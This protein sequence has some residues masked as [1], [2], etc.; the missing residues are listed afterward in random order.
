MK[1]S[2]QANISKPSGRKRLAAR[3]VRPSKPSSTLD[4][5][6]DVQSRFARAVMS[7]LTSDWDMNPFA[8][9]G[10]ATADAVAKFVKPNDRLTSFERIEI[11]NRQYWFRLIDIMYEDYPGLLAV[12]GQKRFNH[13]CQRYLVAYPSRSGL[14][15][16]LGKSLEQFITEQP[17]VTA[18]YTAVAL[19]VARFEW[20]QV[21]AFDAAR[22]TPL[23]V[24]D[25]LGN[26]PESARLGLQPYI[27]ILE[28]DYAVDKLL[29][30]VK[31]QAFRSEASNAT[32]GI[33]SVRYRRRSAKPEKVYLAVH[34]LDNSV[35]VKRLE[36]PAFIILRSLRDGSTLLEAIEAASPELAAPEPWAAQIREWFTLWQSFGWFC[37]R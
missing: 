32:H 9:D 25:L 23:G 21:M 1:R 28:A 12:L 35:Y 15:R 14:L 36:Q 7:P 24:D 13:L 27:T 34:R 37:K 5:L 19:D 17:E 2:R 33:A 3:S 29:I 16:N 6:M 8:F 30:A 22:K 11:Y 10:S 20:A 31:K 4:D 18:P 26:D